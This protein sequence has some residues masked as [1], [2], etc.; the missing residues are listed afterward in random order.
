MVHVRYAKA[1]ALAAAGGFVTPEG[2]IDSIG[3]VTRETIKWRMKWRK[4]RRAIASVS[5]R[6]AGG[7]G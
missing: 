7:I 3:G 5:T 2:G 4:W 1:R 6:F